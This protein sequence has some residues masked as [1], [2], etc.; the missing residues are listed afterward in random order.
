MW[1]VIVLIIIVGVY[2]FYT[3]D[4]KAPLPQQNNEAALPQQNSE[5]SFL[6]SSQ[7]APQQPPASSSSQGEA[8]IKM[9]VGGFEPSSL[10]IPLGTKVHF[11]N[12]DSVPHWPA[13]GV[14]PTHQICPGFDSL[15]LVQ[16][17]EEYSFTFTQKKTC[18]MHDHL[19][20]ALRGSVEVQ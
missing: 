4:S 18:P 13:S 12:N 9:L 8:T 19:N 3:K 5:T 10:T 1:I 2:W 14:H 15:R 6:P 20:P 16:P 11:V 17:G 7:G